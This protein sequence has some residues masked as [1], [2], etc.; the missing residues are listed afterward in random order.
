M[1]GGTIIANT[2]SSSDGDHGVYCV[3]FK[4]SGTAV[5]A[6]DNAAVVKT[7]EGKKITILGDLHPEQNT[8]GV[9]GAVVSAG[10][11]TT[12]ATITPYD[13]TPSYT[14]SATVLT[15]SGSLVADNYDKFVVTPDASNGNAPYH[16]DSGGRLQAG[17]P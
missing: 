14:P 16:V 17:A 11:Y 4:M 2:N 1:T 12:S 13:G 10:T 8:I 7:S 6:P 5:V 15:G 9:D 3:V